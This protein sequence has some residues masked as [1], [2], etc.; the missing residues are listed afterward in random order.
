[1]NCTRTGGWVTSSGACSAP[2]GRDVAALS[3]NGSIRH[4]S[5]GP[6]RGCSRPVAR[7]TTSSAATLATASAPRAGPAT[8]GARTSAAAAATR[9][10]PCSGRTCSTRREKPYNG[11][12]YRN[13]MNP[14]FR[15]VGIGVWVSGGRV[16]LVIDFYGG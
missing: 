14:G 12:H 1:M 6:T 11:G 8:T 2:G 16:R 3:L 13:L 5:R 10:A 15:Q 7:A 4:G 9:T